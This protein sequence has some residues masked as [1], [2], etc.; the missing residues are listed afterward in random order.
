MSSTS[1]DD[2]IDEL[3]RLWPGGCEPIQRVWIGFEGVVAPLDISDAKTLKWGEYERV[4]ADDEL[5]NGSHVT[6]DEDSLLVAR[7][8]DVDDPVPAIDGQS[9]GAAV[10]A[11]PPASS[12]ADADAGRR[13][14]A[15]EPVWTHVDPA[16]G[17]TK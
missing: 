3:E 12:V 9:T 8:D 14:I 15:D 17:G 16:R 7:H 11:D 5:T 6:P 4:V 13:D 2:A 10:V 1:H